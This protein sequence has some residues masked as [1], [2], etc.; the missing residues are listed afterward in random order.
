MTIA[1]DVLD[2]HIALVDK[3]RHS[4]QLRALVNNAAKEVG[5]PHE[6]RKV[7]RILNR[8]EQ[9]QVA[10]A[11]AAAGIPPI[12]SAEEAGFRPS[13]TTS[14]ALTLPHAETF[15]LWQPTVDE[16]YNVAES[17]GDDITTDAFAPPEPTGVAVLDTPLYTPDQRGNEQLTHVIAWVPLAG[18]VNGE[19]KFGTMVLLLNDISREADYYSKQILA[20]A[21][22]FPILGN[23]IAH[24]GHLFP[25]QFLYYL[26]GAPGGRLWVDIDAD[27]S[28]TG[29][30]VQ[31]LSMGRLL[32]AVWDLM[33]RVPPA[34]EPDTKPGEI[35]LNRNTKRRAG[36]DLARPRVREVAYHP[37]KRASRNPDTVGTGKA[38]DHQVTVREH[39]RLQPYGPGRK[40][41]RE[42]TIREHVRGPENAPAPEPVKKVYR[43]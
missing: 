34:A 14:L 38:L 23:E 11:A 4:K 12:L 28:P 2:V 35:A 32:L 3:L 31:A 15:R 36:R 21:A 5:L 7:G 39:K 41:I 6:D 42:I 18:I 22:K 8:T 9:E 43:V 19:A 30:P 1:D 40:L 17:H 27:R 33:G 37:P 10:A 13:A 24:A 25:I 26:P 29:K 16:I 20:D